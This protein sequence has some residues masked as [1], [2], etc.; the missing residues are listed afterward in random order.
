MDLKIDRR[1]VSRTIGRITAAVLLPALL[2]ACAHPAA[3]SPTSSPPPSGARPAPSSP[4]ILRSQLA[5]LVADSGVDLQIVVAGTGFTAT[6]VGKVDQDTAW[7]TIKVPI[8]IAAMTTGSPDPDDVEQAISVSDNDAT[9]HLWS[10]LGEGTGAAD[11]VQKVISRLGDSRTVVLPDDDAGPDQPFGMT[12]WRATDQL[13][14]TEGLACATDAASVRVRGHMARID[15]SEQFGLAGIH[16]SMV[17]GGWGIEDDGDYTIRQM[18]VLPHGG[19]YSAVVFIAQGPQGDVDRTVAT[20][21]TW[22]TA[23]RD[24]LPLRRCPR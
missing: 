2:T 1:T 21:R 24:D 8:A 12:R 9:M 20:L 11:T 23:H 3:T 4:P 13:R 15:P 10:L 17:K 22:F 18:A 16:P 5:A 19:G 6:S 14:F 7:S